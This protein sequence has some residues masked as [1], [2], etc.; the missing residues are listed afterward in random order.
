MRI[1]IH[2]IEKK[3]NGGALGIMARP[4]GDDW[5][6]DEIVQLKQSGV[7]VIV[8]LLERHEIE[9]LGLKNEEN[10]CFRH[11]L[12]FIHFPIKDRGLPQDLKKVNELIDECRELRTQGKSI[13]VHCRMG[14]GRS[15]IIAGAVLLEKG[16]SV[17]QMLEKISEV[18]GLKVPDTEEQVNWLTQF[19]K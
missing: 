8:S 19:E 18:R 2:W 11:D 16:G 7:Q 15:S 14:I 10:F 1:K 13:V 6:E 12:H 17:K 4:R 5:L 9:E 3:P